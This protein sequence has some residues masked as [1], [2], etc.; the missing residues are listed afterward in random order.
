L[1]QRDGDVVAEDGTSPTALLAPAGSYHIAVRHR[2]HL[3]CMTAAPVSLGTAT[4]SVDLVNGSVATFGTDAQKTVAGER[5][6][7][8]GNAVPDQQLRYT[9]ASNDRDLILNAIGGVVP[10]NSITGY[11]MEDTNMDGI[12]KYT[13]AENDRDP[14]LLNIGGVVPTNTRQQQLP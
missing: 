13:G 2:N 1:L 8:T 4:T 3:G 10:T 6:L 5:L 7:W 12:V 11:R 9:G 14:I